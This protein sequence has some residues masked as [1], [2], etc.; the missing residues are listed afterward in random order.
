MEKLSLDRRFIVLLK[1]VEMMD[2]MLLKKS[3]APEATSE[4]VPT[5]ALATIAL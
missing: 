3:Y 5:S 2:G 1:G 4:G